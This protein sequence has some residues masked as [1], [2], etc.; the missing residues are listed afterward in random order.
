MPTT[1]MATKTLNITSLNVR[2]L[3]DN[4]KR[5]NIFKWMKDKRY[6]VVFLQETHCHLKKDE[7]KWSKEWSK[8]NKDSFWSR[9]TSRSKGVA[10]LFN[11]NL[12][13]DQ[14]SITNLVTDPNGRSIKMILNIGTNKYRLLNIYAPNN[15]CERVKFFIELQ[16]LLDDD[17]DAEIIMGGDFNCTMQSEEDRYNCSSKNDVGQIDLRHLSN[18]YSLEDTWR[19]RYPA[20]REYTWEGRGKMSRIDFWL[21]SISLNNQVEDINHTFAPYTD[22]NAVHLTLRTQE[23]A[24]GKGVWK[25]NTSNLLNTQYKEKLSQLWTHWQSKKPLYNDIRT[26]WDVG[27]RHIKSMTIDFSKHI[28]RENI[29]KLHEIEQKI[30][31]LK[32][33]QG[34]TDELKLLQTEYETIHSKG[35]EGA[36]IRSR[37]Q[38]WEEGE[39]STK[40]FHNL[41]KRNGKDK[42]WDKILDK[43]GN[44]LYGTENLQKV[45][46]EFYK[47]L[48]N[49]QNLD[50]NDGYFL[51]NIN[52][53]L[54]E[55]S[56]NSLDAII[57][58]E[59]MSK[60]VKKM[61]NN[62]SPGEDGIPVEFYKLQW[63]IISDD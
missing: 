24:H 7:V 2:G 47:D 6:D 50:G 5:E 26:W 32:S 38:W 34:D 11:T 56:K 12:L 55:R 39:K 1:T 18:L 57:T 40:Y 45:Q 62:K 61:Q 41:E 51:D 29:D 20:K 37:I 10:V 22:H 33:N 27:K 54:S 42:A 17:I 31:I 16:Y 3:R 19:R 43:H 52:T 21:T 13:S 48:Y 59:E 14:M 25:M 63:D 60:A 8:S 44:I 53:R 15:E 9:G 28:K 58:K 36:R 23:T 49:S 4:K 46:V 30:N 35:T